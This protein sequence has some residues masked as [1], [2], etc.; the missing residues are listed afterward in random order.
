MNMPPNGESGGGSGGDRSRTAGRPA[1][2]GGRVVPLDALASAALSGAALVLVG[3]FGLEVLRDLIA[4]GGLAVLDNLTNEIDDLLVD[5]ALLAAVLL[6]VVRGGSTESLR[7]G[8][9]A[10]VGGVVGAVVLD[11]LVDGG[12]LALDPLLGRAHALVLFAGVALATV[13][14]ADRTR[15]GGIGRGGR[16]RR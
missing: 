1:A 6:V 3:G 15:G 13:R 10:V 12:A 8:G 2:D 5:A 11:A 14:F 9:L 16:R 4:G 7:T